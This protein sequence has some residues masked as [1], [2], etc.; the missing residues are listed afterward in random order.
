VFIWVIYFILVLSTVW[1]EVGDV[2]RGFRFGFV[3][4][5]GCCIGI[6]SVVLV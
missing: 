6:L 1:I 4:L 5:N 2:K 3:D